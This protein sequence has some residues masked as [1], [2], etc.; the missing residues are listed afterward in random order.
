MASVGL[1]ELSYADGSCVTSS[2]GSLNAKLMRIP[3]NCM[4]ATF[5]AR[6]GVFGKVIFG[7]RS[8]RSI[9]SIVANS[10]VIAYPSLSSNATRPSNTAIP[11]SGNSSSIGSQLAARRSFSSISCSSLSPLAVGRSY[12]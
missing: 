8:S 12:L 2:A 3:G 5:S 1:E 7:H 10:N 6:P 9:M 11:P 4:A